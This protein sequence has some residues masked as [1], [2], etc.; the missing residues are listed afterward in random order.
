[1]GFVIKF[2]RLRMPRCRFF[3]LCS[4]SSSNC[5]IDEI[6]LGNSLIF[7]KGFDLSD[8]LFSGDLTDSTRLIFWDG[9]TN[10]SILLWSS[11]ETLRSFATSAFSGEAARGIERIEEGTRIS[12]CGLWFS[13]DCCTSEK[14]FNDIVEISSFFS[15]LA[16]LS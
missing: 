5:P 8:F 1:M 11:S 13:Y 12:Y 2:S 6:D 9:E 10:P 3:S 14:R 7:K 4:T 15:W 16:R